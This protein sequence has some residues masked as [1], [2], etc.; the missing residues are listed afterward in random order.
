[1]EEFRVPTTPIEAELQFVDGRALRGTVFVPAST[2]VHSGPE[3]VDEWVNEAASF[4]AF[5]PEGTEGAELVGKRG[6]VRLSVS[7]SAAREDTPTE[8]ERSRVV[9]ECSGSRFEGDIRLDMPDHQRRVIDYV[10]QPG[11]FISL[12]DGET[13]HLIQ[14]R[15]VIR[16]IP[17]PS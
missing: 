17:N 10:N 5:R 3:R 11:A 16:I 8:V 13:V 1:M 2:S 6:V 9:I 4:F 12:H 7:A 15:L 14:K